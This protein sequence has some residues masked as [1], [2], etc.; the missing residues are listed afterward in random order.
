MGDARKRIK[1]WPAE[2]RR[3]AGYELFRI[4]TG[5]LPT[6][7]KPVKQIGA[8]VREIRLRSRGEYRIMYVLW[9]GNKIYVLHAFQKKTQK[10]PVSEI[11][12][13]RRRFKTLV[14]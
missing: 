1:G 8:G 2:T 7:W 3:E 9:H 6:D 11:E 10:T 14:R 13:A 5:H 12:R 4:Q